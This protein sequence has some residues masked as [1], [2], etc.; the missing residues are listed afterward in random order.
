MLTQRFVAKVTEL[1]LLDQFKFA[2]LTKM[3][4]NAMLPA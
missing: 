3:V 1:D 4:N 2:L